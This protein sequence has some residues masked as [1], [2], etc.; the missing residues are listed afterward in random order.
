M[1]A[2]YYEDESVIKY[3]D[4]WGISRTS[5]KSESTAPL[6]LDENVIIESPCFFN[7]PKD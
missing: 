7:L 1:G 3:V 5:Y 2:V 4:E 6:I